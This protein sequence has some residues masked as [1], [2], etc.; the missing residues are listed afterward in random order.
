MLSGAGDRFEFDQHSDDTTVASLAHSRVKR[1]L[2]VLLRGRI[3]LVKERLSLQNLICWDNASIASL[4]KE[5]C[6]YNK[7]PVNRSEK[8]VTVVAA[9]RE[10][11]RKHQK[12]N[13][14]FS[15]H[16]RGEW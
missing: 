13:K 1:V 14:N 2:R 11:L 12:G 5:F 7:L 4:L 10:L 16:N 9:K 3:Q 6:V 15:L 8:T